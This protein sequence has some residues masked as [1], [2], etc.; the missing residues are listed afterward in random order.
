MSRPAPLATYRLQLHAEF[1]F[2]A[3]G[4]I[5]DYLHALGISHVYSSPYLQAPKGSMHGYDVVDHSRVNEELGG[6]TAHEKFC[7]TLGRN[8]LG[9]VLDIVPNH[10]AITGRENAWWWDVLENG[11]AS[12][13]AFYF[14]VEWH[15]PEEKLRNKVLVP[16]LGDHYGRVLNAGQITLVRHEGSFEIRY[17]DHVLPVAPRSM[18][19]PLGEAAREAK[20]DFL[21]FLAD[22]LANLP[23]ATV[24][25]R[26]RLLARNRDKEVIRGLL[27]RLCGE[28]RDVCDALD[29]A[30]ERINQ[31]FGR[32]DEF[33]EKQN[34]RI[35]F[36]KTAGRELGHRRFFDVN[37]L[38]GLRTEA[39]QV[40]ED[41]HRLLIDWL[42]RG[43]VDGLRIDHPDGLLDPKQYF[44]R[45]AQA[46]PH[47]WIV[48]EKILEPGEQLRRDWP[49]AGTTGYEFLNVLGG[50][51]VDREGE[52]PLTDFYG[53]FTGESVDYAEVAHAKK[54]LVMRDVLGSDV[55]QL[56]ALFYQI[57]ESDRNHRDYTRHDI[58]QA[59]REAIA[60]FPVYR[61][62][63][64]ADYGEIH[65]TDVQY[66]EAAV[67]A[68]TL[69]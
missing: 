36:W 59:L 39:L 23:A 11:P 65:D 28:R 31:D 40:F 37:T 66:I 30:I 51:F 19:E 49:V 14:D 62:Y 13:Y 57:C 48:C 60:C 67:A 32:L 33:L 8:H 55:N 52:R 15:A 34:F 26:G 42:R 18:S 7:A 27:T 38:V 43:V 9:Q 29:R 10:M 50:M 54:M 68:S 64:R 6:S 53:E 25:D 69:R 16:I 46:A 35:A 45:L 3:A 58:H 2:D 61:T 41:T 24:T 56:T 22:A 17:F 21:A 4:A 5:A 47:A 12:P 20:S 44:E 63:V 1:D